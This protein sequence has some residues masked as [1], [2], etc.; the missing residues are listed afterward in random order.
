MI[1]E[2]I[3]CPWSNN[4]V[5]ITNPCHIYP[6]SFAKWVGGGRSVIGTDG[7]I[8]PHVAS[9]PFAVS[10]TGQ[11]FGGPDSSE[12]S[13]SV[14]RVNTSP[15]YI[16]SLYNSRGAQIGSTVVATGSLANLATNVHTDAVLGTMLRIRIIN[17]TNQAYD[18]DNSF[19]ASRRFRWGG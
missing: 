2:E 19:S 5:H 14:R 11:T 9:N 4:S 12:L 13:V 8:G 15:R 7:Q 10:P 6:F 16:L 18:P 17:D 3:L 1:L